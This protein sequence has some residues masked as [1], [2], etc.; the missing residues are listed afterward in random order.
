MAELE[1]VNPTRD[2]ADIHETHE[3]QEIKKALSSC[4]STRLPQNNALV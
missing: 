2:E 3:G 4:D 1:T